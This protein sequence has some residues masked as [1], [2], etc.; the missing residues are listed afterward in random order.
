MAGEDNTQV[1]LNGIVINGPSGNMVLN[2]G[3]SVVF[4]VTEGDIVLSDRNIQVDFLTGDM[5]SDYE[6]R[7]YAQVRS[8]D[9]HLIRCSVSILHNL[10]RQ[11]LHP[12][13]HAI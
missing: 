2:A 7:W 5:D 9:P 8:Y 6:V 13:S 3:E 12:F 11:F 1:T 4:N 10:S